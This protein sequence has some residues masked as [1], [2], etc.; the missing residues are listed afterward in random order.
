MHTQYIVKTDQSPSNLTNKCF[1]LPYFKSD[2]IAQSLLALSETKNHDLE[3]LLNNHTFYGDMGEELLIYNPQGVDCQSLLLVGFGEKNSQNTTS[4]VQWF[5]AV[6]TI[7]KRQKIQQVS[8]NFDG[9]NWRIL[10][11]HRLSVIGRESN[12]QRAKNNYFL[13]IE[14][15]LKNISYKPRYYGDFKLL[16]GENQYPD[17]IPV[18][19]YGEHQMGYPCKDTTV[20]EPGVRIQTYFGFDVKAANS[21]K[22]LLESWPLGKN[23]TKIDIK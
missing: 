10:R 23:R 20:V 15:E 12:P 3:E 9:F 22:L 4:I 13:I 2:S 18:T 19:V 11:V 6:T 14:A 8:F 7:L 16:E 5:S 21:F 1:I 17:S